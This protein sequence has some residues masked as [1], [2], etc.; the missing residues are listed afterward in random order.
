MKGSYGISR[1]TDFALIPV[2]E[3]SPWNSINTSIDYRLESWIKK[4]QLFFYKAMFV[5]VTDGK[6]QKTL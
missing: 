4:R 1:D 5:S 6:S 2:R 3:P